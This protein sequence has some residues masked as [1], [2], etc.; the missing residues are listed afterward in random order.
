VLIADKDDISDSEITAILDELISLR[1]EERHQRPSRSVG[2][3]HTA[4]WLFEQPDLR[5]FASENDGPSKIRG[6][7]RLFANW[8][9]K[10]V[11]RINW[12]VASDFARQYKLTLPTEA[13]YEFAARWSQREPP[14][15][16]LKDLNLEAGAS[17]LEFREGF[18]GGRELW[19]ALDAQAESYLA[20]VDFTRAPADQRRSAEPYFPSQWLPGIKEEQK[21]LS[22]SYTRL[23]S[24]LRRYWESL[25]GDLP[26]DAIDALMPPSY[27]IGAVGTWTRDIYDPVW[28]LSFAKLVGEETLYYPVNDG[29]LA[30]GSSGKAPMV[31]AIPDQPLRAVRGRGQRFAQTRTIYDRFGQQETN[32]NPEVGLRC[33]RRLSTAI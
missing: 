5:A 33:V 9:H 26:A 13:E 25:A 12:R 27:L 29:L 32:V 8:L 14:K 15:S 28:P 23:I 6:I 11:T 19:R 18:G 2:P 10:P 4:G 3:S 22:C 30:G 24:E 21:L 31:G 16:L 17:L 7:L 20:N 1:A